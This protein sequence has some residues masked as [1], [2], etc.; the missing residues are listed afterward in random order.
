MALLLDAVAGSIVTLWP[1]Q[2]M[3][4]WFTLEQDV[5]GA[6]ARHPRRSVRHPFLQD[7]CHR[8]EPESNGPACSA[9]Q[10][11]ILGLSNFVGMS[12]HQRGIMSFYRRHT[13]RRELE[14][15]EMRE[16]LP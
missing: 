12:Q 3:G 10:R 13:C 16:A 4:L 9:E 7:T 5:D 11:S 2:A 8:Q 14:S 15:S 1:N 6:C